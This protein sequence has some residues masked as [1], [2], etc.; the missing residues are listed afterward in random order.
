[1]DK[2]DA[3]ILKALQLEARISIKELSSRVGLSLPATSERLRKMEKSGV[4]SGYTAL[5]DREK[6]GQ[7]FCCF[8]LLTLGRPDSHNNSAFLTFIQETREIL[9]CHCVTGSYEY[10]LKIVTESPKSLERILASLRNN[11]GV[12]KSSTYTVL[13]SIKERPSIS[14]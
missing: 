10:I 13:A 3:A 1:M 5:L 14:P 9:E 4:I 2:I 8:C 11:W 6:F 7:N 12:V